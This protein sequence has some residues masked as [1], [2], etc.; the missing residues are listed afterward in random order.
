MFSSA[1]DCADYRGLSKQIKEKLTRNQLSEL[2]S[3]GKEESFNSS[4]V[5]YVELCVSTMLLNTID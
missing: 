4:L 5:S 2:D 1:E 3:S